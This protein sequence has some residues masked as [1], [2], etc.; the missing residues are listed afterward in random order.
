M[1]NAW[2]A[3]LALVPTGLAVAQTE[4]A[5]PQYGEEY[6]P[7]YHFSPPQQW[8]NDPN[9][10]VYF[11]G[12]YHLFYQYHPYGNTW[13]PMHWGHA[14]SKD[15]VYWENLPIA[16]FPDINGAIFSGSAVVDWKNTSGF[17]VDA[18]PPLVAVFTYH[19]HLAQ[20]LGRVDFQ[21]Q[22]IAYSL[23]GGRSWAKYGGN[24][25]L[26]NPGNRDFRDPKVFWY[27]RQAKWIMTLAVSDHVSFYSS[28]DLKTWTHESDFG[29]EWGAHGGVWECP[30]LIE[31]QID[32]K[33]A[34][35]FVLLVSTNPGGPNGGS[36][37][38]YF[39]GDFDGVR[40]SLDPDLQRKLKAAPAERP[41]LGAALWLDYGTDD[42]A[43]STWSDVRA[44]DG[45]VLF[46]GWMNN[47]E[48][49]S[50]VPTQRWRGAMTIPRELKLVRTARG[51]EVHSTPAAELQTLRTK[52]W[53]IRRTR[54]R[55]ETDL[56]GSAGTKSGLFEVQLSLKLGSAQIAAL[57][58][59]NANRAETVFRINRAAGR[60]ELDRSASGAVKF[61]PPFARLQTAPLV[62]TGNN[63]S[64]RVFVDRS[65]VEVF[66]NGGETVF[67]AI[68]FPETPY[69]SVVLSADR[70]IE[71]QSGAI[72]GL[73]S[74]WNETTLSQRG[75]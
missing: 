67:T 2:A 12:T 8:M 30:D 40:F 39:L 71:L 5:A 73:R 28:K 72:D 18:T 55:Q 60:Y 20:N 56:T 59:R 17:G 48:Y 27:A 66:V 65:S 50:K 54:I 10:L 35:K 38:Q 61:S 32:G 14:I 58:L 53:P 19:D 25:V 1:K 16:L 63:I 33:D 57:S 9:G 62:G 6:R 52:D 34:R 43:G 64:L 68:V 23:D 75:H 29:R 15:M 37:T 3:V 22:G 45:R 26:Q 44:E 70:E 13:G 11:Q 31:M 7:Q 49:A 21:T 74:I 46:I 24:P 41:D 69:D 47:W 36:A 51:L 42:Y 4:S